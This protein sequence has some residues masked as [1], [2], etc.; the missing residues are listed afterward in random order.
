MI[1]AQ[2]SSASSSPSAASATPATFE[3]GKSNLRLI[4]GEEL[5]GLILQH[6]EAFDARHK[7]LLPLRRVCVPEVLGE[8]E[9]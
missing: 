6:Y 8:L 9:G 3:Q 7:G 5:V 2:R 4:D 1:S